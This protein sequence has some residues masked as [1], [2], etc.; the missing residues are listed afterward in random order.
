MHLGL[1]H[2]AALE[3]H[4]RQ[5]LRRH[6]VVRFERHD[7]REQRLGRGAVALRA[8]KVVQQSERCDMARVLVEQRHEQLFGARQVP[9]RECSSRLLDLRRR[10]RRVR[11]RRP[12]EG[13][14]TVGAQPAAARAG[15]GAGRRGRGRQLNTHAYNLAG[16]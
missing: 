14:A 5:G 13:A 11:P 1:G 10:P 9:P 6:E 7:P 2:G 12:I 8:T 3:Q 4:E 15:R 16:W